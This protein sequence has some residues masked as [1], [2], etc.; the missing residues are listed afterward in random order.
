MTRNRP[1]W[2]EHN[3]PCD[4]RSTSH[5]KT[6]MLL[7]SRLFGPG[8]RRVA[9][10]PGTAQV[11]IDVIT[12]PKIGPDQ[13]RTK[14]NDF[15]DKILKKNP[16]ILILKKMSRGAFWANQCPGTLQTTST[17]DICR[18]RS[19]LQGKSVVS[20]FA[21]K[22]FWKHLAIK[23]NVHF[24]VKTTKT[25]FDAHRRRRRDPSQKPPQHGF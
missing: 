22:L 15:E 14:K 3:P 13:M 24:S 9:G 5:S 25:V 7:P 4:G 11:L 20:S 17:S 12:R 2:R 21:K 1:T 8:A 18:G 6:L 23:M 19:W 10:Y 16:Q